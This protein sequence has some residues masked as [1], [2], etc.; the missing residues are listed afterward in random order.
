MVHCSI[1]STLDS[2]LR[3]L[4]FKSYW[5]HNVSVLRWG[6]VLDPV[7][8]I[9]VRCI[10]NYGKYK[11]YDATKLIKIFK[12]KKE[13]NLGL[14]EEYGVVVTEKVGW[15]VVWVGD[16]VAERSRLEGLELEWGVRG[17][18]DGQGADCTSRLLGG[19]Q[20][21]GYTD[22]RGDRFQGLFRNGRGDELTCHGHPYMFWRRGWVSMKTVLRNS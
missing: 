17:W 19:R 18:D 7:R 11:A 9:F 8:Y 16:S 1:G 4:G 5:R 6:C 2:K 20:S 22:L 13:I 21:H 3:S 10:T 14:L 12:E 15:L